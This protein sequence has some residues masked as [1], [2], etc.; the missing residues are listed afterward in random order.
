MTSYIQTLRNLLIT[1]Q[2]LVRRVL[3]IL[4]TLDSFLFSVL[5]LGKAYPGE[6]ISSAAYRAE[7]KGMFFGKARP[8]IDWLFS[9]LEKDHCK[10]AYYYAVHKR[11]LPTDMQ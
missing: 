2:D 11:N 6:T 8:A 9:R 4:I 10:G 5:T 1:K 3:N 7:T